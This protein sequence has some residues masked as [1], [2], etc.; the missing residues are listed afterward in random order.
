MT[1]VMA[2]ALLAL[3]PGAHQVIVDGVEISY[4]VFGDGPVIIAH[5]GG[6]GSEWSYLRMPQVEAFA[7]V[8]YIEPVGTGASGRLADP[9]GYTT[10]RYVGD[11]EALRAH[12]GLEQVILLGHSHGGFVA[13]A[14]ALAHPEHLRGL[15]LFDTT[16]TTGRTWQHNVEANLKWFRNEPWFDD[17]TAALAEETTAATDD[18]MTA[19]FR[20]ELPLYFA[21]WTRRESEFESYRASVRLTVAPSRSVTDPS[22][23]SQ[24]GVAPVFDVRDKLGTIRVPTLVIAGKKD[25]VC[26]R[27]FGRVLHGGIAGSRLVILRHSGHM[28]HVE[29][30][31]AFAKAIRGFLR[32]LPSDATP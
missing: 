11:V 8:V 14:Y 2:T 5:P 21:D 7:T 1:Q 3:A 20:R 18:E 9:R 30:P 22:S 27:Q 10:E 19:I 23:P 31:E 24:V 26:S 13:Q 6:P 16:P 15:I 25:F 4:R 28:G 17:A 32:K 29:E 12:L